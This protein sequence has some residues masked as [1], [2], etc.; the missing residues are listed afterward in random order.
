VI[1]TFAKRASRFVVVCGAGVVSALLCLSHGGGVAASPS[2]I[3]V[4]ISPGFRTLETSGSQRFTATVHNDAQNK[5]VNWS[6]SGISCGAVTCGTLSAATSA[7][8]AAI[9]YIAPSALPPSTEINLT[10]TSAA[11]SSKSAATTIIVTSSGLSVTVSPDASSVE[12]GQKLTLTATV[13]NNEG[14]RGIIWRLSGV[15]CGGLSC[16]R[17]SAIFSRPGSPITY[18]AP[19]NLPLPTDGNVTVRAT[20]VADFTKSNEATITI[21]PAP[22]AIVATALPA[23]ADLPAGASQNFT[24]IVQND[25]QSKGVTW[26][27]LG[28]GCSE[29]VCGSLSSSSSASGAAVIYTAPVLKPDPPAIT[30]RGTSVTDSTKSVAITITIM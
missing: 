22:G 26:E 16:G 6:L 28:A 2:S 3:F 20:S 29:H 14:T 8:G 21:T 27:L 19:P 1:P 17:L 5:G 15:G 13:A 30:L 24:A 25:S 18:T 10:A 11:D 4:S 23:S 7:S 12:L 9:T